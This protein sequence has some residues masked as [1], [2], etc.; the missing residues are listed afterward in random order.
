MYLTI[1]VGGLIKAAFF[2]VFCF[3]VLIMVS[4]CMMMH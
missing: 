1:G 3:V 2:V 4:G